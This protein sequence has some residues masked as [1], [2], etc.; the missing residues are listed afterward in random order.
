MRR[1]E[2]LSKRPYHFCLTVHVVCKKGGYIF[3][4]LRY[5]HSKHAYAVWLV[6][7]HMFNVQSCSRE[8]T[9]TL[10]GWHNYGEA[11]Q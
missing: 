7:F 1:T 10:A 5:M 6:D 9:V 11:K 8:A 4:S 2:Y 3:G